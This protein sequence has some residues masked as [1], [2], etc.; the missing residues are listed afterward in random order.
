MQLNIRIHY[1]KRLNFYTSYNLLNYKFTQMRA[2][3]VDLV[4]Y[5]KI[6]GEFVKM[7]QKIGIKVL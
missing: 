6:I 4:Q 7:L 5:I 1:L 3:I 2:C